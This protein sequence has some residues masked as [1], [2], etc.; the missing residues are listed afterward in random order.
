MLI[1][2]RT[3]IASTGRNANADSMPDELRHSF[4]RVT[5]GAFLTVS[6]TLRMMKS[7]SATA[8]ATLRMMKSASAIAGATLRMMKA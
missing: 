8:S 6:A 2:A 1:E 3:T 7:A 5:N 4:A